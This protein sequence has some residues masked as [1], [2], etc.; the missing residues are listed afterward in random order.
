MKLKEL[1]NL[2]Q[3]KKENPSLRVDEVKLYIKK[4]FKELKYKKYQ[5][6]ELPHKNQINPTFF[7]AELV[8][9]RN[10]KI[11]QCDETIDST[12]Q[13][14]FDYNG[15]Q[16]LDLS[17]EQYWVEGLQKFLKETDRKIEASE[18]HLVIGGKQNI[19]D[20]IEITNDLKPHVS[21][22]METLDRDITDLIGKAPGWI[23]RSGI[24]IVAIVTFL[25]LGMAHLISYPDKITASGIITTS[26]PPIAHV[27]K[28]NLIIDKILVK[29]DEMVTIAQELIYFKNTARR[30]DIQMFM[31]FIN[32]F[33]NSNP[34]SFAANNKI[35]LNLELGEIQSLYAQFNLK[36]KEFQQVL[37]S[38]N[39]G[40]Q[41][42]N[43]KSEI[44]RTN[45]LIEI[46]TKEKGLFK[47]E[48]D[49]SIKDAERN[50]QLLK[51]GVISDAENDLLIVK[52]VQMK[53]Q[54]EGMENGVI[55]NQ[56]KIDQLELQSAKLEEDRNNLL[57]N[58]TFQLSEIVARI[59]EAYSRWKDVYILSS[60][61]NGTF[62]YSFHIKEGTSVTLGTTLGYI[63]SNQGSD[64]KIL[65]TSV[66]ALGISELQS[67]NRAIIRLDAYPHKEYGVLESDIASISSLPLIAGESNHLYEI[68]VI[69]PDK[70]VTDYQEKIEYTPNMIASV[71]FIT[72]D[73]TI[74]ER[75]MS[76]FLDLIKH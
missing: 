49:L 58:Y 2:R 21:L 12:A 34:Y 73:K 71:D 53:R 75:I 69:L 65:T 35:L 30:A 32:R 23:L 31:D 20:R 60:E 41:L 4:N 27:A 43:I 63:V 13:S 16:C 14:A 62:S 52:E 36:F 59:N 42:E 24:S 15:Y 37:F 45:E 57:D 61:S 50:N 10:R 47:K 70:L 39:I 68:Q 25:I 19:S 55:Q 48:L 28:S 7:L 56:I 38:S 76:Q 3:V 17:G 11:I 26:N 40:V 74:L 1:I 18:R 9:T 72:E 5:I 51:D 8:D 29:N 22:G 6:I 46:Q 54:F 33:E 44:G 64:H 67:G 66:E